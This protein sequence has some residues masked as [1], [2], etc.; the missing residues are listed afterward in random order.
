VL[1]A[2]YGDRIHFIIIYIIDPHPIGSPS[3]YSGREWPSSASTD[4]EGNPRT[5]PTTYQ[6]RLALASEMIQEIEITMPVL[7]DEI[8]NPVWCTYGPA[9]DIAYLIDRNGIIV[10]KQGWYQPDLMETVIDKHLD[11][12]QS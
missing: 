1:Y 12:K 3:P 2:K 10:E 9:P 4:T 6:E 8:D 7:I 11:S 5:Q